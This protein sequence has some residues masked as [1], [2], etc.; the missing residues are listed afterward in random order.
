MSKEPGALHALLRV[1]LALREAKQ[2][3]RC[4][5][6]HRVN[7]GLGCQVFGVSAVFAL[8][9]TVAVAVHLQDM[10]VV[11]EPVQQRPSQ[12]LGTE[13]LGPLIER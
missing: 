3:G 10:N 13:H 11:C 9:E 5:W 12:A 7:H 6:A 1:A 2:R 8:V 4:L